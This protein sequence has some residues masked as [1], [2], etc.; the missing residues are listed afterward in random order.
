MIPCQN[1]NVKNEFISK[2]EIKKYNK[3]QAENLL[4]YKDYFKKNLTLKAYKIPQLK[5]IAKHHGL[6]V[7]G[8]KP[9]LIERIKD[10]FNKTKHVVKIQTVFRGWLV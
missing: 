8:T 9:I 5:M 6:R 4:N 2:Q 3:T 7:T 1:N 10:L